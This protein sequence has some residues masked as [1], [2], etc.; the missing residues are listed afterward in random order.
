MRFLILV[1]V[2]LSGVL[3]ARGMYLYPSERIVFV[4][5]SITAAGHYTAYV[6]AFLRTRYPN[7]DYVVINAGK[8]SETVNGMTEADHPGPRP[9]IHDRLDASVLALN[10]TLVSICYGMN[11]GNYL[12]ADNER[13]LGFADGYDRLVRRITSQGNTRAMILTPPPYH[14]VGVMPV[15]DVRP[16]DT[17]GYKRPFA[18]YDRVLDSFTNHL[19]QRYGSAYLVVDV[20]A[21]MNDRLAR[22]RRTDDGFRFQGDG[23]HPD[24]TGHFVMAMMILERW[25]ALEGAPQTAV[26]DDRLKKAVSPTVSDAS[27]NRETG[28]ITFD[29]AMPVPMSEDRSWDRKIVEL[30]RFQERVNP[31]RLQVHMVGKR[32]FHLWVDGERIGEFG[33]PEL[34]KGLDL[35]GR[36]EM[37]IFKVADRVLPLIQKQRALGNAHWTDATSGEHQEWQRLNAEIRDICQP[38]AMKVRLVP[39]ATVK[40]A[41]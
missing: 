6:E 36:T 41:E 17:Y 13:T 38:R 33:T 10:P 3:S 25:G 8:G 32:R 35:T 30:E 37:P 21:R 19:I 22:M 9:N 29:W 18:Y 31:M 5:D 14:H 40:K 34:Q 16:R 1:L 12:P 27:F 28:E 15:S 2:C 24:T 39:I 26:L 7:N 23:I 4:G 11:D 20:H